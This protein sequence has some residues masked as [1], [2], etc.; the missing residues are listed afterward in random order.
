M[1]KWWL[2]ARWFGFLESPYERDCCE[3][4]PLEFQTANLPLV[5][6]CH[7]NRDI[8]VVLCLFV[9]LPLVDITS[10]Y[11]GQQIVA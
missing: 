1:V 5:D 4:V 8:L 7:L 6:C 9:K 11:L 3:G 10:Q 2:G